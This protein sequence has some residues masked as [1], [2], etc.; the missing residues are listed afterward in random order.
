VTIG[1]AST[2]HPRLAAS[3]ARLT[4]RTQTYSDITGAEVHAD[5]ELYAAIMWRLST[6]L[7]G[8]PAARDQLLSYFVDAMNFIPPAPSY[9]DM[10]TGLLAATPRKVDC[11]VW[12]AFASYGVGVGSSAVVGSAGVTVTESFAMPAQCR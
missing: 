6:L 1:S 9:E 3:V 8:T 7:G 11:L 10:R 4:R 12:N 5:G 2:R